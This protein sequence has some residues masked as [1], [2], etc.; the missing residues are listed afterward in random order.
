MTNFEISMYVDGSCHGN[1]GPAGCGIVL[2]HG[3]SRKGIS[4][5]IGIAT[6]N[7][8]EISAVVLGIEALHRPE[9][10]NVTLYTDSQYVEGLLVKGWKAKAN[11]GL[12]EHMRSLAEKLHSL[13]VIKVRGHNGDRFNER[14]D[15]LANQGADRSEL[16]QLQTKEVSS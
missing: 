16:I 13:T 5:D 7:I 3:D 1:P 11:A 12:V 2:M 9:C 8:A 6:N 10:C 15:E 14:A 4:K